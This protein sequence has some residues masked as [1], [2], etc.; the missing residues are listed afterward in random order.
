[1]KLTA[2]MLEHINEYMEDPYREYDYIGVRVQD[3]EFAAGAIEHVSHIWIDGV[4]TGEEI[5]G[6][7][8]TGTHVGSN[9]LQQLVEA[10]AGRHAAIIGSNS[11]EYGED[12]GEIILYN[13]HVI[14]V[15]A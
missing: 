15:L 14:E 4:D 11:M 13:A 3:E 6:I 1:M 10:Y 5:G 2:E 9:L 8:A 12:Q 7:C